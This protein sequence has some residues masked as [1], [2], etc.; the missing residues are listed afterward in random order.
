MKMDADDTQDEGREHTGPEDPTQPMGAQ[1]AHGGPAPRRLVRARE[2]RVL[3]GVCSGLG[4]YFNVDPIL[5]RVGAVALVLLGGAGL[6]LYL[7]ALILIPG[8]P[9]GSGMPASTSG[10][11]VGVVV[12]VIVLLLISWPFLLGGGLIAAAILVPVAAL[13]I[14]GVLVWWL[15]SGE[16]PSGEARDIARRAALGVGVLILCGV[17]AIGAGFAAAFG[18]GTVVAILLIVAGVALVAGA[19][20]RP[21]RWLILP[22]V[23]VGLSAGAVGAAGVAFDGGFGDR[24]YTPTTRADLRDKYELGVGQMDVNLSQV[25]LPP[26]DTPLEVDLGIGEVRLTVPADVCV[27]TDADVGVGQA[28]VL[29]QANDGVDVQVVDRREAPPAAKRLIL[30]ADVGVGALRVRDTNDPPFDYERFG[31][32]W[33]DNTEDTPHG[34]KACRSNARAG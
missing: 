11:S 24:N 18:G 1:G 4:R 32:D 30:N 21:V 15:V 5:F 3:G 23:L 16:G 9:E 2:G 13:V 22:A 17:L 7:A 12:G 28:R 31:R 34:N 20:V 26:G 25:D 27:A 6:L 10:R 8:E 29:G 33:H 19:F 14:A